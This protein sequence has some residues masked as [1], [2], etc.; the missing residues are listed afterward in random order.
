MLARHRGR[1]YLFKLELDR[2]IDCAFVGNET[3]YINHSIDNAN[4]AAEGTLIFGAPL[5]DE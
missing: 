5:D 3:R 2:I 4:C 1:N